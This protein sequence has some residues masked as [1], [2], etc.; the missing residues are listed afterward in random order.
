MSRARSHVV[1]AP[2]SSLEADC[3]RHLLHALDVMPTPRA[4]E[5]TEAYLLTVPR[6]LSRW[7][8][9]LPAEV[10][11]LG[12]PVILV[13]DAIVP[14]SIA[15][16]HSV[17]AAGL[18]SWA[19]PDHTIVRS[20]E[21]ALSRARTS[22]GSSHRTRQDPVTRLTQRE[23][24][25]MALVTQGEHDE[26]IATRLGISVHTVRSHVQHCLTKLNVTHRHAAVTVI[27][28]RHVVRLADDRAP[29]AWGELG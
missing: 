7:P 21:T 28:Q 14:W 2:W 6:R 9:E 4:D 17:G 1:I 24:Q 12:I 29:D 20:L 11:S 5:A 8:V 3:L 27:R 19:D 15:L 25:I 23:R 16:G 13:V 22:T 10:E 18:V 26:V